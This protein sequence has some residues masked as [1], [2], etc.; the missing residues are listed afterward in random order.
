MSTAFVA[1]AGGHIQELVRLLPAI[2]EP[3]QAI[4]VT[5]DV[6]QARSLLGGRLVI[7]A[8]HPTTKSLLNALRNYR[9]ACEILDEHRIERVISTGA[10]VA[11]PFMVRAR[12]RGIPC[13]Y[14]ESAA[15]VYGPSLSGRMLERLPGVHRYRQLGTWGGDLWQLGPSVF[16]GFESASLDGGAPHGGGVV[17]SVGTHRYPFS[18]LV[19]RLEQVLSSETAATWQSSVWTCRELSWT[20][21]HRIERR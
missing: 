17:V 7:G 13:H 10:A 15:R 3:A 21:S 2:G 9:L 20:R 4:W 19:S 18:S 6:P 12:Q 16:D 14:I 1:S 11:V 5:Y 8:H